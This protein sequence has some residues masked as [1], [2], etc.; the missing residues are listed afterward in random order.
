MLLQM[1]GHA[2]ETAHDGSKALEISQ[3]QAFDVILLDIGLPSIDG[4]EVARRI[5]S[6]GAGSAPRL[7]GISGYGFEA[8]RRRAMDAGF[9]AYLVKPVDPQILERL[10][11]QWSRRKAEPPPSRG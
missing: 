10:L 4:Y 9:D 1:H 11:D 7:V 8:D 3:A 2:V 6:R 5:R